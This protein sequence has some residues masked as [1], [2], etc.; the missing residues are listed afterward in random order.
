MLD[1]RHDTSVDAK[2]RVGLAQRHREKFGP[3]VA[4]LKWNDH[5]IVFAP[6]KLEKLLGFVAR[7]LSFDSEE[8]TRNFF[9][10]KLQRDRRY[11]YSNMVELDFDAQGRLTIPKGLRDAVDLYSD[12]VWLGCGEYA[13]LWA[14]K[15]HLADC[16]RWEEAGGFDRL[17][18]STPPPMNPSAQ[19]G[20]PGD[21]GTGRAQ[22]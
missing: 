12:V 11:F 22:V 19:D 4:L 5:L 17:F 2:G 3:V 18:G 13:E 20:Q 15:H 6:D 7:R 16:A 14:T 1:W 9:D 8:G 21:E 10:P